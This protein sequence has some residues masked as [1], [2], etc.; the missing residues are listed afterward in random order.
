MIYYGHGSLYKNIKNSEKS[1]RLTA[2]MERN[3]L[4]AIRDA[5]IQDWNYRYKVKTDNPEGISEWNFGI[6]FFDISK[7][8]YSYMP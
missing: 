4:D 3:I 6:T 7:V 1:I 8:L 2:E 5:N